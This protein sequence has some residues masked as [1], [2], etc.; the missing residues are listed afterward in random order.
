MLGNKSLH[1]G[2]A[3]QQ[4]QHPTA[5]ATTATKLEM[6]MGMITRADA[7]IFFD[8]VKLGQEKSSQP[9][10]SYYVFKCIIQLMKFGLHTKNMETT[11]AQ[12]RQKR[13]ADGLEGSSMEDLEVIY[14]ELSSLKQGKVFI[15]AAQCIFV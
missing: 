14:A 4:Q 11:A 10:A 8:F 6:M 12:D 7:V 3:Q 13:P 9:S 2:R 5:H 1:N 15:I